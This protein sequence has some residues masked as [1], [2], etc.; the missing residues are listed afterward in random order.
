MN[1][2]EI[3]RGV[4]LWLFPLTYLV[5]LAEEAWGGEGFP[6]W[7][8]R[9]LG[10]PMSTAAWTALN[11]GFLIGMVLAIRTVRASASAPWIVP[12]LAALVAIN[13]CLHLVS[14]RW[15]RSYSPGVW[16]GTLL[17][18]PLGAATLWLSA[19]ELSA[20]SFGTGVAAGIL[21]HGLVVLLAFAATR[22][23]TTGR[24]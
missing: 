6:R 22:L 19:R 16:S 3:L 21:L 4:W 1:E 7:I 9:L 11:A 24:T 20:D 13:A 23:S 12:G 10:R 2:P 17:W 5:H 15:T 8:G 14:G 18:L